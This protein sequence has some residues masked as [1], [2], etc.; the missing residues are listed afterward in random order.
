VPPADFQLHNSLFLVAHFHTMI[1]SGVLFGFLA[2]IAYWFPKVFGFKLHEKLGKLV[3]L[4]WI[5]G[6]VLAFTPL[7][8]LGLMGATRRMDHYDASLGWQQLFIVAAFGVGLILLGTGLQI[9]QFIVSIV[10]RKNL[11]D[12]SGDPWNGR[13]L[14][15]ATSSP[16]PVYN[17]AVIPN[18]SKRDAFWAAKQSKVAKISSEEYEDIHLPKN[19][20][21]AL[22]IAAFAFIFGFAIIW[23]IWWL[24]ALGFIGVITT[25]VIRSTDE[26]PE[27]TIT[28]AEIKKM[29]A[30]K[31]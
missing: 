29:E 11:R 4:C 6:F 10:H 17:F 22:V 13:T 15:W 28:A 27:Y 31:A 26:D 21:L 24:A 19:T 5:F 14:E 12:Q 8:I 2:G 18:A 16:A 25:I 30:A 1:I 7:Y 23:H 3:A 9:L 20:P